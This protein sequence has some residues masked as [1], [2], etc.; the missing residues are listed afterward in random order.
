MSVS[1][2]NL[3][4]IDMEMTGLEPMQDRVLEIAS[5]VTDSQ[6]NVLAQGPVIAVHQ[7]EETLEKMDEWCTTT[8]TRSGLVERVRQSSIGEQQ[9]EVMTMDFL[10]QWVPAGV[11]PMC[12]NSIGQDRR[13]MHHHMPKLEKFFHY[14][15]IDVS[16]IKEL[17]RRW[18]PDV[19]SGVKKNG[20]HLAMDDILESID[21]LRHYQSL[22]FNLPG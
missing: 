2:Q 13:F 12:G 16:S 21:E 8:H 15:N 7:D 20:N 9:A 5:V 4:W 6:L 18:R 19:L 1:E 10:K 11:S 17:A 3:I 22:F 14:R